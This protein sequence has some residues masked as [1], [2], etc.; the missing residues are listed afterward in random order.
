MKGRLSCIL[1]GHIFIGH[2]VKNVTDQTGTRKVAG[3]EST[4][5]CLQCGLT[6]KEC[7][8]V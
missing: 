8:I 7:R 6:K 4:D 3:L 2:I 5:F 1:F